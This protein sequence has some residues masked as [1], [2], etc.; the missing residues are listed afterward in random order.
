[1]AGDHR[2]VRPLAPSTAVLVAS[3]L[4]FLA[5]VVVLV[6]SRATPSH[7]FAYAPHG[8]PQLT[9]ST[10]PTLPSLSFSG[11]PRHAGGQGSALFV[12]ILLAVFIAAA[13]VVAAVVARVLVLR[14]PRFRRL[15]RIRLGERGRALQPALM[16]AESARDAVSEAV[17]RTIG[18]IEEGGPV[19]D[20]IIACW[21]AVES[22]LRASGVPVQRSD[23]STE[24]VERALASLGV[25]DSALRSLAHLYREARFS[26]HHLAESDRERARRELLRV[27]EDLTAT[28]YVR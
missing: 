24:I 1:M 22:A 7:P 27:R 15:M 5:L 26:T 9:R 12:D 11:R 6:T 3:V 21:V 8:R 10:Q 25:R 13:L 17:A 16:R 20:A 19:S 2:A 23:T 28:S 14:S 4:C 18:D